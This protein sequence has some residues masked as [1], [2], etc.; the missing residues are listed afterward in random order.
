ELPA[1]TEPI[2]AVHPHEEAPGERVTNAAPE[3]AS[4]VIQDASEEASLASPTFAPHLI[5]PKENLTQPAPE[6]T[7]AALPMFTA[8]QTYT[9]QEILPQLTLGL[10][11]EL[12]DEFEFAQHDAEADVQH[13]E[14]STQKLAMRAA[15]GDGVVSAGRAPEIRE[16]LASA[17]LS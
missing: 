5:L 8:Q 14:E 12:H 3:A 2:A 7:P 16:E 15:A 13:V 4:Q 6:Q 17:E 9:G 1:V 11:Q 10:E